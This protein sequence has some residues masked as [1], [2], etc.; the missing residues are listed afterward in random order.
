MPSARSNTRSGTPRRKPLFSPRA[1]SIGSASSAIIGSSARKSPR[2]EKNR[3]IS[4]SGFIDFLWRRPFG[5]HLLFGDLGFVG[6]R[7]AA[8]LL[9]RPRFE[10]F[11]KYNEDKRQPASGLRQGAYTYP[12]RR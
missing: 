7:H 12:T 3:R 1:L 4:P 6:A 5:R 10:T 8:P 2:A 9:R 11:A